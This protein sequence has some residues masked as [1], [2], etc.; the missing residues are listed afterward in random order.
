MQVID[1]EKV[2]KGFLKALKTYDDHASVQH[3]M[4][5]ELVRELRSFSPKQFGTVLEIGSGT[6]RF[7][8]Y[9]NRDTRFLQFYCNELFKEAFPYVVKW[10]KKENFIVGDGEDVAKLPDN[11]ELL[12]SNATFQWFNNLSQF[13]MSVHSKLTKDAIVAFSTFGKN[14]FKE[15]REITGRS[16]EYIERKE[17]EE[18]IKEK[19]ETLFFSEWEQVLKFASIKRVLRHILATGVSGVPSSPPPPIDFATFQTKYKEMFYDEEMYPLTYHPQIWI[20]KAL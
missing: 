8:K 13:L 17:L 15:T 19:Y 5:L 18:K 4:G 1:K 12:A 7:T 11:I 3:L 20:L 9:L 10:C 14:Q 16:L 6:G 2:K